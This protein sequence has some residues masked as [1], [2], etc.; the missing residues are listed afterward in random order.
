VTDDEQTDSEGSDTKNVARRV[1]PWTVVGSRQLVRDQWLSLRA[2]NCVTAEGAPISSYYVLEYRDW[3]SVIALDREDHLLLVRQYRHAI[4]SVS[5][6]LPAGGMDPGESDPVAASVRE[7]LEETGYGNAERAT[8]VASLSPN[9]PTHT[10]RVHFV[11]MEGVSY[12]QPVQ[13]HPIEV[14]EVVRVPW[15]EGLRLAMSGA[16]DQAHHVAALVMGLRAAGKID[17]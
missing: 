10:N 1:L 9:T 7:L 15:R 14:L 4:G 6:E 17:I 12:V 16:I 8:L 3:I 2:D 11:L 5:L 13:D